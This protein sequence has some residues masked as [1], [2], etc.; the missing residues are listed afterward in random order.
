ME[1]QPP[2]GEQEPEKPQKRQPEQW[3]VFGAW[4]FSVDQ[5]LAII[6]ETPREPKRLPVDQWAR[7]YGLDAL[8][9]GRQEFALIGPGPDFNQDYAMT[10]DLDKPVIVAT[11]ETEA[12]GE[13]PL[14]IDGTHRLYRAYAEGVAELPAYLLGAEETA[15]IQ[16][17]R[18]FR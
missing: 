18:Y 2:G 5:A 16:Q 11:L 3:F 4:T 1:K 7:F 9:E 12:V 15:A 14:L 10:T 6:E 8:V 13:V 17:D